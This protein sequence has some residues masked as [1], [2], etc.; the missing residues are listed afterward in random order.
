MS[1]S[2]KLIKLNDLYSILNKP[3]LKSWKKSSATLDAKLKMA[4]AEVDLIQTSSNQNPDIAERNDLLRLLNKYKAVMGYKQILEWHGSN[5]ELRTA[6]TSIKKDH[7]AMAKSENKYEGK[8][9]PTPS[10]T[11]KKAVKVPSLHKVIGKKVATVSKK[12]PSKAPTSDSFLPTLATSLGINPK[13][14]RQK[15]RKKFGSDWR[16]MSESD[17][18]KFL[19][20]A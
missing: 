1:T 15:L 2:K 11:P 16:T 10:K 4:Q 17:V 14:A 7:L 13:V 5:D 20:A 12:A 8:I 3:Q 18:K 6:I 19:K 9:K